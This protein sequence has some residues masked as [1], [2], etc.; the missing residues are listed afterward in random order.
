MVPKAERGIQCVAVIPAAQ[1]VV[2]RNLPA[3]ERRLDDAIS[4]KP[5]II[6]FAMSSVQVIDSASLDWLLA[7]ATRLETAGIKMR[8]LDPS[9]VMADAL[10]AT[11]LDSRFVIE[12][13]PAESG[14]EGFGGG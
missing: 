7:V 4:S 12:T 13:S 6:D 9:A 2:Q 1:Q 3:L 14:Q 5:T 11:R 10:L 8:L